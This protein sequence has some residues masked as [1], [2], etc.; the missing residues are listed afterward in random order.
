MFDF[1]SDKCWFDLQIFLLEFR[2]IICIGRMFLQNK[3]ISVYISVVSLV[4]IVQAWLT[5]GLDRAMWQ[6]TNL[7]FYYNMLKTF[8]TSF[9]FLNNKICVVRKYRKVRICLVHRGFESK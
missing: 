8:Q 3:M 4:L 6:M 5:L 7:L 2:C 1:G 9:F